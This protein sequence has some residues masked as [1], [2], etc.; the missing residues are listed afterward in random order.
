MPTTKKENFYFGLMMCFGM[1][2]FMTFYN[3]FTHGLIGTIS[4]NEIFTQLILVFII[5][6]LLELFIVGPVAKK[7]ALSLPFDKS[8]KVYVILSLAF[9]MVS[10]MVLF[11][12]LYGL[13][14]A[15]FSDSLI[16]ES[17]LENYFS[18]IFRNFIFAFPLQLIIVGPL[19]RYL[20]TKF[21]KDKIV[22]ESLS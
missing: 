8:K 9:F 17:L 21:V 12:S 13:G 7:I 3:L 19:V 2:V 15:Y 11:M 14:T 18:L 16:G 1:V 5:A 10:G 4:L 22:K 6:S 20:F